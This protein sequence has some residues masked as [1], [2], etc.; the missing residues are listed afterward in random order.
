MLPTN[1]IAIAE[2]PYIGSWIRLVDLAV[3]HS[4]CCSSCAIEMFDYST[5]TFSSVQ[6]VTFAPLSIF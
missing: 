1:K 3:L 2:Y 6:F 4:T 5:L